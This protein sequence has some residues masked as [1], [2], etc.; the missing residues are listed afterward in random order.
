[1]LSGGKSLTDRPGVDGAAR[2]C[3]DKAREYES[4][5]VGLLR[6]LIAIP[7]VSCNEAKLADRVISE[8]RSLGIPARRD[9][10]G[11]VIATLGGGPFRVVYDA[12]M[13]TVGP[14]DAAVWSFDPFKGKVEDGRVFGRGACD[15]K[16]ALAAMIAGL[17][18]ASEL[19]L[20]QDGAW[21]LDL[22]GVVEEEVAEGWAIGD[23]IGSGEVSP[24]CVVLGECTDLGIARG[25][26]GRCEF[27]IE[28]L[29]TACHGSSPWRG[30]NAIYDMAAWVKAIEALGADLPRHAFLGP[31]SVAVTRIHA[32]SGSPNVVP[33]RC[34]AVVDWRTLPGDAA[35]D[36]T[37]LLIATAGGA[38]AK[39]P[40]VRLVEYSQPSYTGLRKSAPKEYPAWEVPAGH[41][42]V[43]AL[44]SAVRLITGSEPVI[45]KW[46]FST[47]GV[48]TM[49]RL[50]IPTIGFGPGRERFAHT[51][52][53]QVDIPGM[54]KA[55][56]VYAIL[57]GM[58]AAAAG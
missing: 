15:N 33:E 19:G 38:G 26:R 39:A 37:R 6:D 23:A 30:H 41:C 28:T 9:R 7:S 12:H 10:C 24:D 53:D 55:A 25:H 18:I 34:S 52:E 44:S 20:A 47:D 31:A 51:V 27:G 29:G 42:F 36:L 57:P 5:V 21:Q 50:G 35:S 3:L 13:D 46:E 58:L 4:Y 43:T 45:G 16:G 14:G 1:M 54:V 17:R 8:C 49:G 11:S 2:A 56:A 22:V 40:D 48:M 32:A